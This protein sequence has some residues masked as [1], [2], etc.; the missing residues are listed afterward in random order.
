MRAALLLLAAFSLS[1]QTVTLR[2]DAS[3]PAQPLR[4]VWNWF[5]ADEPNYA[6]MTHGRAL[7]QDLAALSP[8][9][10]YFRAHNLL[11]TGDGT[12]ALKWGS[13]NAYTEDAQG[14]AVYDWTILDRIFDTYRDRGIRPLVE[15]G[16]MPKALS[17]QPE[18]YQHQWPANKLSIDGGWA[19]PPRDYAKFAAL[20]HAWVTHCVERYGRSEVE[21]WLW[22]LWNEPNIRYWRGTP[23]EYFRLYDFTADAVK[24]ALPSA[25]IGG[26]HST[27]PGSESAARFLRAFLEHCAR[28]RNAV[29]GGLGAP[30][31]FIAFH[32]K[33]RPAVVDGHVRMNIAAQ[34]NDVEQGFR[35]VSEFP[36]FRHK[37]VIIGEWDPEGCAACSAKM[38]PQNAYRNGVLYASYTAAAYQ[39]TLDLARKYSTNLEGLVTWAFEFEG[40]PWFEGFRSLATNGVPKPVLNAFRM[41]G[42]LGD[43]R[44]PA[45]VEG[46][47]DLRVLATRS[48]RRLAV[49]VTN[50]HDDERPAPAIPARLDLSGLPATR[51]LVR[52]YRIDQTHSNSYTAWQ[53]LGAPQN[54][55]PAQF[56]ELRAAS[57]LALSGAPTWHTPREGALSLP[58]EMPRHALS[59]IEISW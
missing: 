15:I 7:L 37:P 57:D 31:D 56:A 41:F 49:L 23:E 12:A 6:Y 36:E 3:H 32:A 50:Y 58:I 39:A 25:R 53:R 59:L 19:F 16:F 22:E 10:V 45:T 35:I 24:R 51:L 26:P 40:Q 29:T 18:P 8:H 48:E 55:T 14:R 46:S 28:G 5:G 54:P 47:S 1:A 52:H 34:L 9:P 38:M 17:T 30:L 4:P 27:G 43:G 33:G 42:L 11:T 44:L 20:V 13:T 2:V 21:T